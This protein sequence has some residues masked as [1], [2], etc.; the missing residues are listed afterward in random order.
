MIYN[1]PTRQPST[2]GRQPYHRPPSFIGLIVLLLALPLT[3]LLGTLDLPTTQS[4]Q[5]TAVIREFTLGLSGQ[6]RP[7]E[8]VQVGNGERKLVVVGNTHGGPEAN[9]YYLTWELI[10]HFRANPDE[11]PPEVRLYFIPSLNPDGLALGSRF[12]AAGID[13]NRNMN[14]TFDG[15]PETDWRTTVYGAYGIIS[16]TGGP[17]ADSQVETRLIRSFLL[18]ASGAIFLHS[19]AGLVFPAYCEHEPSIAMAQVYAQAAG[20]LY[21]RYWPNYMITGGMHDWAASL[22]IASITPELITATE[23]EFTN[24]LAGLRAVLAQPEELLP[25]PADQVEGD[26]LIPARIWRYWRSHGGE[27]VFGLPLEP[28]QATPGGLTQTF[29]HARLQ[30]DESLADTPFLVQPALLGSEQAQLHG[31]DLPGALPCVD[32]PGLCPLST[33]IL[34]GAFLDYWQRNGGIH[35]FGAPLSTEFTALTAD[36][37]YRTVQYFERAIFAYY[38]EDG[39]VR[40]EPLGWQQMLTEGI[41]SRWVAPQIR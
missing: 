18:D 9:T 22:G 27:S 2:T 5:A 32:A 28:A 37:H 41:Q 31:T 33:T 21:N 38:P 35:V 14:T 30:L 4:V 16:D 3:A 25:L 40:P 23:T 13:L 36:G 1:Q 6:G 7:I 17:F 39:S 24:N 15:C 20:Y 26:V 12:D 10:D 34:F 8:V 19:N 11:V 29:T